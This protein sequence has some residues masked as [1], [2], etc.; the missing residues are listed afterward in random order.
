MGVVVGQYCKSLEQKSN[1]NREYK[2]P[3]NQLKSI[4]CGRRL[5][6]L[7]GF[8]AKIGLPTFGACYSCGFEFYKRAEGSLLVQSN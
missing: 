5:C 7:S 1:K 3:E 2:C 6:S 4:F 8:L